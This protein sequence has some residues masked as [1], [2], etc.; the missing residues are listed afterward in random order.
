MPSAAFYYNTNY[1]NY[2]FIYLISLILLLTKL[3]LITIRI[4]SSVIKSLNI[5]KTEGLLCP[6]EQTP[7]LNNYYVTGTRYCSSMH[8][9]ITIAIKMIRLVCPLQLFHLRLSGLSK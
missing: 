3:N 9:V 6:Y 4:A 1:Y 7:S 8:L 5:F 2:L